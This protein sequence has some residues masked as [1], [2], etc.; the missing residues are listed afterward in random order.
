MSKH[1]DADFSKLMGRESASDLVKRAIMTAN[2]PVQ[3]QNHVEVVRMIGVS[4]IAQY[5]FNASH[6]MVSKSP[7]PM[8]EL[9][10]EH[11]A[12]IED[13]LAH[14]SEAQLDY[15]DFRGDQ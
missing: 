12:L 7:R 4:I 9:I 11:V 1:I 5:I 6:P 14:M 8:K 15:V 10:A 3:R 2:D 13:E